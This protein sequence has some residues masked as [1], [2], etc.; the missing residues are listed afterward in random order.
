M[1]VIFLGCITTWTCCGKKQV[2]PFLPFVHAS[3]TRNGFKG[4]N[5]VD[6]AG[7]SPLHYAALNG[8]PQ[9]IQGLL[10]Q[11]ADLNCKTHKAAGLHYLGFLVP[12]CSSSM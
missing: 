12:P 11:R 6:R 4:V 8:N 5:D 7:W 2:L 10:E 3:C 1:P 9:L